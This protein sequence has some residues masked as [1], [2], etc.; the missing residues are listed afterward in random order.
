MAQVL[1]EEIRNRIFQAAS[2]IFYEKDFL[3]TKMKEI[4]EKA[5]IPV[6]LV[7][8][9]YKNKEELFDAIVKPV[10]KHLNQAIREE[11]KE[12]GSALER[13]RTVGEDYVYA[14]LDQHKELVI[15]MDKSQGTKHKHAKE[16]F[17]HLLEEHIQR[18]IYERG[19]VVEEKILIHILA[20]NFTESLLE[21]AR[22]YESPSWAR[23]ILALVMKC[24][25]EGV[26]SL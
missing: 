23:K 17:I 19:I 14:M 22:H 7:Y 5:E 21:I 4:A 9:Y 24:Y 13:F 18:R 15:L 16:M 1:K 8:S 20:S 11:E 6:G 12:K 3:N 10:Y 25:Y 2:T 26:D